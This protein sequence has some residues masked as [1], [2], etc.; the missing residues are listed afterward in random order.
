MADIDISI[1]SG[2]IGFVGSVTNFI[3]AE[4]NGF[5]TAI[6][7]IYDNN[8]TNITQDII[9][10]PLIEFWHGYTVTAYPSYPL[11]LGTFTNNQPYSWPTWSIYGWYAPNYM[12]DFYYRVHLGVNQLQLGNVLSEQTYTTSLWNA[13]PN[14][15]TLNSVTEYSLDGVTL[16]YPNAVP[17]VYA[18]LE[19]VFFTVSIAPTGTATIDGRLEFTFT[20]Q[21][22]TLYLTGQRIILWPF[23]PQRDFTETKEWLTDV[24]QTRGKETR[25]IVRNLPRR[26]L[27]YKYIF[28]E[29]AEFSA[30][31]SIAKAGAH[32]AMA[33]P[34]WSDIT[35]L[36]NIAIGTSVFTF[37]TTKQELAI[38]KPIVLWV[39]YDNYEILEIL[40]ITSSSI[41]TKL[42]CLK[43][44]TTCWLMPVYSG[45]VQGVDL[46]KGVNK[47][48]G[49]VSFKIF[50]NYNSPSWSPEMFKSLPVFT[51][52]NVVS[53][54]LAEKIVR[55]VE[56]FD[57]NIG[58]F[59]TFNVENYTRHQMMLAIQV[60]NHNELHDLRRF[61]EYLKGKYTAFWLPSNMTDLKTINAI[62]SGT[63][64]IVVTTDYWGKYGYEAIRV[65]GSSV[66]NFY[67][68]S[69]TD[70]NDG[71]CTLAFD[72]NAATTITGIYRIEALYKVR[73][74][75]D[76]I[77]IEHSSKN[78][79]SVKTQV[80]TVNA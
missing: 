61:L 77:E 44:Y 4:L 8:N 62:V 26:V 40:S 79:A 36:S 37:D 59:I 31:K 78:I 3:N 19:Q 15:Y 32:L 56:E 72:T 34:L 45:Y 33:T 35:K 65:Y 30:A 29:Q 70:N 68:T 55:N 25:S 71:T 38:D 10:N 1:Q 14:N 41:T 27:N 49:N 53:A 23:A 22:A 58:G 7:S 60:T 42:P 63:S 74:N 66:E 43:S 57:P 11:I 39:S 67:V 13:W 12:D 64:A 46:D 51:T 73:L 54:G 21:T 75:S 28:R 76:S 9:T 6:S 16:A 2:T 52:G 47:L 50:D 80:I 5:A 48:N 17:D 69:V 18:P 24:I 20:S